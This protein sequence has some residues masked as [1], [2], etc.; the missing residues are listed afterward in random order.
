MLVQYIFTASS[1]LLHCFFTASSIHFEYLVY[2]PHSN[3]DHVLCTRLL[4]TTAA[5]TP[6]CESAA[7]R[8]RGLPPRRSM[9]G[10]HAFEMF[11]DGVVWGKT[12][13]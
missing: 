2:G 8:A 1:L 12:I 7:K 10:G 3:P 4:L 5:A 11:V 9:V 6:A 13:S